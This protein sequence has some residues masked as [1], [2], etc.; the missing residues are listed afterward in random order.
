[1]KILVTGST[2]NLGSKIVE[3]LLRKASKEE[4]VVGVSNVS[5]EKAI[6]YRAE[7]LDVRETNFD[8]L[9]GLKDAFN[10]IDRVFII[11]TFGQFED[12][13]RQHTNAIEA[14]K[15]AGVQQ[16]VYPSVTKADNS[17]HFLA[18]MHHAREMAI[19]ESGIPS[20]ILRNNWYIENE[21]QTIQGVQA[22]MPWMTSAGEGKTGWVYRPDLA[23]AAANVLLGEGHEGKIYE[24]SGESL[25]QK[26]F[27]DTLEEVLE[28]E[29][30]FM[31]IE[32]DQHIEVLKQAGL[33]EQYIPMITLSQKGTREG[34]LEVDST[35]LEILLGR[36]VTTLKQALKHLLKSL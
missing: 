29:V 21:L 16:I 11:S 7:G 5:S 8:T 26:Q 30:P 14:A 22:G 17:P 23:E 15:I 25:T 34:G 12:I 9:Q 35:D 6:A 24:L 27:V 31:P 3:N 32:E 10:G 2:G 33:P 19:L 28:I 18:P 4:I 20:V 36:P 1:M 13:M